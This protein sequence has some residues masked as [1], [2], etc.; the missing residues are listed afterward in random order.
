M[1][2]ADTAVRAPIID[3][4]THHTPELFKKAI[5]DEGSWLGLDAKAGEL[6]WHGFATPLEQRLEEMDAM[7][8]D[9]NLVT[10]TVGFYQY[11]NEL[12]TT[13]AVHRAS[14]D[15]IAEMVETY[16]DRFAGI[17]LLPMQDIPSAIEEL[18]RVMTELNLK[19]VIISDHV[20]GKTYDEI[21]FIP[22]FEAAED[23]GAIIFF[24]QSQDTITRD[25]INRYSLGNS[26]GNL[27]ERTLVFATL[28]YGGIMDRCPDLKV[29]LGHGG[30]YVA[31]GA[32]RMDK[33]AG[34]LEGGYPETGLQPPFA[35]TPAPS[36]F[37]LERAPS[38]YLSQ[39][40]YDS[41]TFDGPALRYLIDTVGIDRLMLGTDYP[42][43]MVQLDPVGWINGLDCLTEDEKTAI[44]RTNPARFIGLTAEVAA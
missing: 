38:S 27:T 28:V 11:K 4:H 9:M 39:F 15:E 25:R 33:A 40:W 3:I 1:S 8:V 21:E 23:L 13:K 12:E 44:L 19:G 6:N 41:C 34:A 43:P 32:G 14:N 22:F 29:L 18:E 10:P 30:G 5:R 31:F 26:I 35:P 2:E 20:N 7:G 37:T 16:P 17:G 36:G 24:H 42:A